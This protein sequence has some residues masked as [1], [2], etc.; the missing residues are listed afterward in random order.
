MTKMGRGHLSA[1]WLLRMVACS[2]IGLEAPR[3]AAAHSD[4]WQQ[5]EELTIQLHAEPSARLLLQRGRLYL[6]HEDLPEALADLE[7]A[8]QL[9][10]THLEPLIYRGMALFQAHR[11]AEALQALDQYVAH[12]APD[13]AA[14]EARAQVRADMGQLESAVED[15]KEAIR[16]RP[17]PEQFSQ[18]ARWL[19][20]LGRTEEAISSYENGINVLGASVP[21]IMELVDLEAELGEVEQALH[22][23]DQL[24]QQAPRRE[25]WLLRRAEI[26]TAAG[27]SHEAHAAYQEALSLVEERLAA[28]RIA[29]LI[30][31]Q[32]AQAL[33]GLGRLDESRALLRLTGPPGQQ[34]EEYR[35]L[36]EQ[37]G[38]PP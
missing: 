8:L 17:K 6:E 31:L 9:D 18:M 1:Q 23:V 14:F 11:N 34:L 37:L 32:K 27:R 35:R 36:A 33:A 20:Q 21:L 5:I 10:P 26:L 22:W 12:G 16:L 28:G 7:Q 4:T 24:E 15:L 30:L 3:I 13:Y 2:V 29:P 19:R 38:M 25:Q